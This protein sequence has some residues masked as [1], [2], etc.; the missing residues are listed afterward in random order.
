MDNPFRRRRTHRVRT[1]KTSDWDSLEL[2]AVG[3]RWA[4]EAYDIASELHG[5]V[6]DASELLKSR[7]DPELGRTT[8]TI[9]SMLADVVMAILLRLPRGARGSRSTPR[10]ECHRR[11]G[12]AWRDGAKAG[13]GDVTLS[14]PLLRP[15]RPII[16]RRAVAVETHE[17]LAG[18][19]LTVAGGTRRA[20]AGVSAS[21]CAPGAAL[22]PELA[23]R[24]ADAEREEKP[25]ECTR[26]AV[27]PARRERQVPAAENVQDAVGILDSVSG[28]RRELVRSHRSEASPGRT[29]RYHGTPSGSDLAG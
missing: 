10:R 4:A 25:H 26:F 23:E 8:I 29:D 21:R 15:R 3:R 24:Q 28:S 12:S 18:G 6:A 20:A 27:V 1:I 5:F 13:R 9:P 19:P 14:R 2:R 22:K 16:R 7:P 17:K 11:L